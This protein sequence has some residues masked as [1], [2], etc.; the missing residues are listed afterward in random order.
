MAELLPKL[1]V[2]AGGLCLSFVL[3]TFWQSLRGV[4]AHGGLERSAGVGTSPARAKLL[5]EKEALLASLRE[6][7][8]E[9]ELGKLADADF[10]RL[11]QGYR[12]R[13]REVL[14]AL[15]E[16]LAPFRDEAHTLLESARSATGESEARAAA[17][18]AAP[19][20]PASAPSA[21]ACARCSTS[22]DADALFCK[23]CG[24]KLQG[25]EAT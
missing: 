8:A 15:D 13:A 10:Q 21:L 24:E 18:A 25:A 2:I 1:L 5:R 23:K 19:D 3:L 17:P 22:N 11:D 9:H 6:L 12:A 7:R 4:I 16:Q 20:A 14:R